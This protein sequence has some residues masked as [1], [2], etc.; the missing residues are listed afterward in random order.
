MSKVIIIG[1]GGAGLC[2]ALSAKKSGADVLVITK[3]YATR[4]QT[5]MAQGGINAVLSH[6]DDSIEAHINDTIKSS[7]NL[8]NKDRVSFMCHQAPKAIEWLDSIGVNF[9]RDENANIAQRKLGGASGTRACYAKDYTGLKILHTLYDRCLKEGIEF[10][11]EHHALEVLVDSSK[12]VCGVSV[13]DKISGEVKH[14]AT[15]SVVMATGGFA[16][17]YGKNST[18]SYSSMGDGISMALRAG[19]K[20]SGMEFIQFHPTALKNSSILISESARGAGGYLLNSKGERFVDELRSRDVVARAIYEE[21]ENGEDIFLDIRH[22]DG[23]L[24]DKELPQELKLAKLYEGVDAKKELIGIKPAAHYCMGGIEVDDEAQSSIKG[25]F[26]AGE[27][28]NHMVHGAN[29]LGGNSLLEIVVF[30]LL[31][32]ENAAKNLATTCLEVKENVCEKYFEYENSINFYTAKDELSEL[33]VKNVGIKRDESGLKKTL[34]FI[35]EL[36]SNINKMGISDKS[37]EYNTNLSDF[38]E[39]LSMLD[40]CEAVV[41]SAINAKHSIGAHFRSD[42]V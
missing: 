28:A 26:A 7:A 9:S 37:R 19:A 38:L 18:N 14:L 30:G 12:S 32:G 11:N 1:A 36:K 35:N 34:E 33:F 31:A 2:A 21:M 17:V 15:N 23:E 25:L 39:F 29:R 24:L 27:C 22:I 8:A 41:K 4:S 40:V 13:L 20:L 16:K 6:S 3:E 10:L 5:C 42:E